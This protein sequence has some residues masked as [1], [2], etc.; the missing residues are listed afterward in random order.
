MSAHSY[1]SP[2]LSLLFRPPRGGFGEIGLTFNWFAVIT[3]I[4][5]IAS[6]RMLN[7]VG[8]IWAGELLL[9]Q[10]AFLLLLLG[11]TRPLATYPVL[12]IFLQMAVL[13]LLGY[14]VSDIY[15]DA[16][17]AQF[18]RGW[19]RIIL[20]TL[21][22][23]ALVAVVAH[24]KRN[25]WWFIFGTAVGAL[26]QLVIRGVPMMSP[27]GWKFGWSTP[28][29]ILLACLACLLPVKLVAVGFLVL[30][31]ANIFMDFRIQGAICV[32]MAV[33]LWIRDGGIEQMT[34]P[35]VLQLLAVI[36]AA[37]GI[38]GGAMLATSDEFAKR[39]EQSNAG[40]GVGIAVAAMAVADSPLIGYGSWPTDARLVN[41][42]YQ[43]MDETG[44]LSPS[45]PRGA[46]FVAHSQLLQGW[47]EGGLLGVLF[48]FLYGYGLLR[49][50]WYVVRHRPMDAYTPIFLFF[51]IYN[52]WAL[53]MSGFSGATRLPIAMG[54]VMI[55]ICNAEQ[56]KVREL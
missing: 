21:D 54:I 12:G 56:R 52:F 9:I 38:L 17:P 25:L 23:V 13:M 35:R 18:L 19:S 53:F 5:G 46:T 4:C 27:A 42:Y 6:A 29:V 43:K 28:L 37:G 32:L 44:Q 8:E 40:R 34:G 51:L 16:S 39:R 36:M 15:R 48:W 45:E 2:G 41:L 33:I 24:D 3:L 14:M 1:N 7:F 50:G 10:C 11:K 20:L 49:A 26:G 31:V 47:V 55:C 22:F 30:G